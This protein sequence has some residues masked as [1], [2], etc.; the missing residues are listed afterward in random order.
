MYACKCMYER[1]YVSISHRST[2]TDIVQ[3]TTKKDQLGVI[4]AYFLVLVL[5]VLDK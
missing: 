5:L 1:V 3:T 2:C 4:R